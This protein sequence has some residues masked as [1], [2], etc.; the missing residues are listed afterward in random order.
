MQELLADVLLEGRGR[1]KDRPQNLWLAQATATVDKQPVS[2]PI[3]WYAI[4][5]EMGL[6][7]QRFRKRFAQFAGVSPVKYFMARR[8]EAACTMLD[9]RKLALKEIA[10]AC[11]FCDVF[12]FSKQFKQGLRLTPTEYRE[13]KL[14]VRQPPSEGKKE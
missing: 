13:C 10:R 3:N 6:S 4:S 8:L 9:D 1:K 7:Y 2:K 12:Q 5:D 11:G 14:S